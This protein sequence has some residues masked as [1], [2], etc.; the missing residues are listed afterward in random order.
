MKASK[1]AWANLQDSQLIVTVVRFLSTTYSS[2]QLKHTILNI[3]THK[4]K[5]M[6]TQ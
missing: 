4:H 2:Q 5:Y 1:Y 6:T 3:S